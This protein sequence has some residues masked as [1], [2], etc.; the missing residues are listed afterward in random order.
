MDI[1][2]LSEKT[3]E[4]FYNEFGLRRADELFKLKKGDLLSLEGFK[5]K[6]AEN[7]IGSIEKSKTT[8]L[9]RF[10]TALGVPGVGKKA[11]KLLEQTF[12]T[13]DRVMNATVDELISIEDFGLITAS[14]IVDFFRAEENRAL[15][16]GLLAQG[17]TFLEEEKTEGVFSG[18]TVVITG[19]LERYKRSAAQEEV[20]KRGGNVADSV[21]KNVNLVIVGSDAGSKLEKAKKLGIEIIDE[22]EFLRL[23]EE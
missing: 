20:K 16:E 23:L 2:G 12:V 9:A 4:Q 14:Q 6:K 15:I 22:A 3:I 18:K 13:L 7:I 5:E 11:A 17:I 8:T 21:S 19:V 10:L 1:D